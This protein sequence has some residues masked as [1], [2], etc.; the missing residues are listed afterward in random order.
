[1]GPKMASK[2]RERHVP[3]IGFVRIVGSILLCAFR[4]LIGA[5][6]TMCFEFQVTYD[7][8]H[9]LFNERERK[10]EDPSP[11]CIGCQTFRAYRRGRVSCSQASVAVR[12]CTLNLENDGRKNNSA[13]PEMKSWQHH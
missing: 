1:M 8:R 3:G 13:A 4:S 12:S 7:T 11:V 2:K 10:Q 5:S 6:P 9:L